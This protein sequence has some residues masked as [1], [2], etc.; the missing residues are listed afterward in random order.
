MVS[1]KYVHFSC[2]IFKIIFTNF[3]L[4]ICVLQRLLYAPKPFLAGDPGLV[5]R[6]RRREA[7]TTDDKIIRLTRR[8][9]A[10]FPT[11]AARQFFDG[12]YDATYLDSMDVFPWL[13]FKCALGSEAVFSGWLYSVG[14]F[15]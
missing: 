5:P 15:P 14:V 1:G 13:H 4:T 3:P 6:R 11:A 7:F 8:R 2:Q 10:F 9:V 12:D